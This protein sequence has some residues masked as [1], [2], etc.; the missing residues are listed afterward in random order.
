MLTYLFEHNQGAHGQSG[1]QGC[2]Q[3]HDDAH[4]DAGVETD[5]SQNPAAGGGR[6]KQNSH[7]ESVSTQHE[8]WKDSVRKIRGTMFPSR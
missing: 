6:K 2:D 3:Q 1:E 5:E 4:W 7:C 8:S